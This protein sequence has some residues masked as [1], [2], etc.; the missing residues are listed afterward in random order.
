MWM[1][2]TDVRVIVTCPAGQT[3]TFVKIMTD[4]GVYG[5][6]E[7]AKN[8]Q[9][10]AVTTPLDM[11]IGSV[12]EG[13]KWAAIAQPFS[14]KTAFH[15]PG[16]VSPI[17]IRISIPNFLANAPAPGVDIDDELAVRYPYKRK[18]PLAPRRADGNIHG[19]KNHVRRLRTFS[20]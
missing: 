17:G 18:Y 9:K 1:K 5:V 12:T 2:T 6:G 8:D 14:I 15:G 4:A 3:F 19:Y 11:H 16:G 20:G 7:G 10:S 13:K